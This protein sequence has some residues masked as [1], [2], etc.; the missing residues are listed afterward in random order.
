MFSHLIYDSIGR[1]ATIPIRVD[2]D[3]RIGR[4]RLE[5][6]SES[7]GIGWDRNRNR[8]ESVGIGIGIGQN[9]LGSRLKSVIIGVESACSS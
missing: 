2:S 7:V 1:D 4:N 6:E 3:S 8:S 5:S 9:R